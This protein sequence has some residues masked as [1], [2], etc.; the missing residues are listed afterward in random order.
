MF[1]WQAIVPTIAALG[2]FGTF[3]YGAREYHRQGRQKRAETFFRWN[4]WFDSEEGFGSLIDGE[5]ILQYVERDD[6]RLSE[7]SWH[8]R[9]KLIAFFEEIALAVN[10]GLLDPDVATYM[11]GYYT[12]KVKRSEHFWKGLDNPD[13]GYW[14]LWNYFARM[15]DERYERVLAQS[16][17]PAKLKF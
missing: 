8:Q 16:Y 3:L 2:T 12:L 17:D 1:L 14:K 11:F 7:V 4:K 10:S 15:V 6:K 13:E 9:E 5:S